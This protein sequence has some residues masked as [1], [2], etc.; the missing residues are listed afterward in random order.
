VKRGQNSNYLRT[1]NLFGWVY[2]RYKKTKDGH[3]NIHYWTIA[4]KLWHSCVL[5]CDGLVVSCC[6]DKDARQLGDLKQNSFDEIWQGEKY[7]EFR[8]SILRGRSEIDICSNCT[9]GAT[10]KA[11]YLP[12]LLIDY[13]CKP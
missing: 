12:Y 2:S 1:E 3:S 13:L 8:K 9:E 4:R 10:T 5:T 11:P 7:Q 6:F